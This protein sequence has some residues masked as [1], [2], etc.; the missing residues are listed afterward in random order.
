MGLAERAERVELNVY[1][2]YPFVPVRGE[3]CYLFD[4]EGR[5]YLD[6]YAG[7]AVALTGHCHPHVVAAIKAQAEKLIF[8]SN[9]VHCEERVR[10]AELLLA[11]APLPGSKAFF[12]CSGS[13]ANENAIKVARKLTGRRKVVSFVN[14]FHGRTIGTLSA[15]GM[16]KYLETAGPVTLSDHVHVPFGDLAALHKAVDDDTAAVLCETI[17]SLGGIYTAKDD[18]FYLMAEVA[19]NAGALLIFDEVQS[20][21]GR[22]G[23]FFFAEGVCV[24]PDLITMAKGLASGLPV[25]AMVAAPALADRV[26][27]GDLGS[28][29]GGGPVPMAAMRATLE[30]I[31]AEGLALNA[32]QVGRY[33][34]DRLAEVP[35]VK[36]VRGRGL[37]LGVEFDQPVKPILAALRER[38]IIAGSSSV[39]HTLRLLP[40]LIL[41]Q[42]QA[43][44]FVDTLTEIAKE[45]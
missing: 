2:R 24:K 34:K 41:T 42:E 1:P 12:C 44:T 9:A 14:A 5:R 35:Q 25:G 19:K 43:G 22:T 38:Q 13:E 15:S 4:E 28:T 30:V 3:G 18:F 8:Y 32:L 36:E 16:P 11:R 40:P 7:H 21:L 29:F 23:T 27:P 6:L 17:Q 33:L 20:G 39:P 37:L 26:K 31:E 10:A 45:L